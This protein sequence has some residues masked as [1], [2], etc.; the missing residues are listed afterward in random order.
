[1]GTLVG[2]VNLF[3]IFKVVSWWT[4]AGVVTAFFAATLLL[5]GFIYGRNAQL[6][7]AY[8]LP[9]LDPFTFSVLG[10]LASAEF[11][12]VNYF[13]Q[14]WDASPHQVLQAP[15]I[16]KYITRSSRRSQGPLLRYYLTVQVPSGEFEINLLGTARYNDSKEGTVYQVTYRE[17]FFKIPWVENYEKIK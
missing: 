14:Q 16:R 11:L 8:P 9:V 10:I 17:G 13:N 6:T 15:M 5:L 3:F 4:L 12:G 2:I 7:S 1:M